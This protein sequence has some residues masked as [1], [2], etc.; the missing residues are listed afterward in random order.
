M[1]IGYSQEGY[2]PTTALANLATQGIAPIDVTR[3]GSIQY[4]PL[5]QI[6]VPSAQPEL[7]TQGISSAI[8]SIGSGILSPIK[9]KWESDQALALEREKAKTVAAKEKAKIEAM[10]E[11]PLYQAKIEHYKKSKENIDSL[12][13]ARKKGTLPQGAG[14]FGGDSV[15]EPPLPD[16]ESP[17]DLTDRS[18]LAPIDT[19]T[20]ADLTKADFTTPPTEMQVVLSEIQPTSEKYVRETPGQERNA[21]AQEI[22]WQSQNIKSPSELLVSTDN[23]AALTQLQKPEPKPAFTLEGI[24]TTFE[25]EGAGKEVADV[26]LGLRKAISEAKPV[27]KPS[28]KKLQAGIYPITSQEDADRILRMPL[29][30]NVQAPQITRNPKTGQYA[31]VVRQMSP[32]EVSEQKL[33]AEEA[34]RKAKIAAEAPAWSDKQVSVYDKLYSNVQ[35]N[36][37]IKNAIDAK[38]SQQLVKTSLKEDTGFGDIAAINAFQRMVDPGV[39]VREGDIN[40]MQQAIPRLERMGLNIQGWFVGDRLTKKGRSEMLS[41]ANNLAASRISSGGQAIED[42]RTSAKNAGID[43][44]LIVRPIEFEKKTEP[45]T[46]SKFKLGQEIRD[47]STGD[48]LKWDGESWINQSTGEKFKIVGSEMVP[49]K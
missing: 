35:Q 23:S 22:A 14:F 29:A 19:E 33:K 41:I 17:E 27:E 4:A 10:K 31:Y 26:R 39:A 32:S 48:T 3:G 46:E 45:A 6:Q 25:P 47:K 5:A 34:E 30:E 49:V 16:E 44:D 1:P 24:Q 15:V 37:L 13:E 40:L 21:I 18:G 12:I 42:L 20:G 36:P 9:A 8:Q 7:V 11:D 43:P 38:S 28:G 2:R